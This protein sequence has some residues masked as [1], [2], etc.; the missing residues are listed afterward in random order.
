[1]DKIILVTIV[2][3]GVTFFTRSAPFFLFH[4]RNVPEI[5][6]FIGNYSPPVLMTLLVIYAMKGISPMTYP[7][8]LPEIIAGSAV[9]VL[10]IWR[11]NSLLS[12]FGGT[13]LYMLLVQI[14]FK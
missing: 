13:I 9:V 1:M 12:I 7:Y 8:G 4:G 6:R 11:K 14:I 2:M 3:T 10:H 5:V